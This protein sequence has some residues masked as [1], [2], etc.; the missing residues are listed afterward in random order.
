MKNVPVFLELSAGTFR[1]SLYTV[2]NAHYTTV[3]TF[4][5]KTKRVHFFKHLNYLRI[6]NGIIKRTV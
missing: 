1:L 3:Q 4:S 5:Y 2:L 6:D